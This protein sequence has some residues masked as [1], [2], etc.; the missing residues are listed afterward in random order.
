MVARIEIRRGGHEI[1]GAVPGHRLVGNRRRA[2]PVALEERG[3]DGL[4]DIE[5]L[6]TA[7]AF[8][9]KGGGTDS[10]RQRP[11]G[12]IGA[13]GFTVL[14]GDGERDGWC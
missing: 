14:D 9:N 10:F 8:M 2:A 11:P 5:A 7:G 12:A 13:L 4:P 3:V 1:D 6:G